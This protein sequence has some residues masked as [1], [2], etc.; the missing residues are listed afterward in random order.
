MFLW[1]TSCS[2]DT[3]ITNN[4][5]LVN[6]QNE[7]IEK[8]PEI[9]KCIAQIKADNKKSHAENYSDDLII[10]GFNDDVSMNQAIAIIQSYK[11]T[12]EAHRSSLGW[13]KYKFLNVPIPDNK[14]ALKW[15]CILQKD[16][17]IKSVG[18]NH[19]LHAM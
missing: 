18:L 14:N 13:E 12:P 15:K 17:N 1:L 10:V 2:Q 3:I 7:V 11:L 6:N 5:E 16:K 4:S 8:D 19:I 9:A